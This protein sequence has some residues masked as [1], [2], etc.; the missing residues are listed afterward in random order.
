MDTINIDPVVSNYI[1][2]AIERERKIFGKDIQKFK[3][4]ITVEFKNETKALREGFQDDIKKAAEMIGA[5]ATKTD[6]RE[7]V[8]EEI[9]PMRIEI[10]IL[11][12]E[13][14]LISQKLA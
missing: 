13:V 6:V 3:R 7:I 8:Q 11:K 4:E 10:D 14:G 5:F 9:R 12:E 2:I 1:D